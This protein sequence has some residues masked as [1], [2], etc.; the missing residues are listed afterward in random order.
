LQL[1]VTHGPVEGRT[2]VL[3][4]TRLRIGRDEGVDLALR[5]PRVSREHAELRPGADGVWILEDLGSTNHTFVNG[6]RVSRTRVGAGDEIQLG[7][8]RI[9]VLPGP[10]DEH[11]GEV[12]SLRLDPESL[13]RALGDGGEWSAG[14]KLLQ[15]ALF[16]VG[17]LA[18]PS[19]SAADLIH[20]TLPI[21]EEGVAFT[22]WAWLR[23]PDGIERPFEVVDGGAEEGLPPQPVATLVERAI[24]RGRGVVGVRSDAT[25]ASALA[26]PLRTRGM[27]DSLLYLERDPRFPTFGPGELAWVAAVVTQLAGHLEN[28]RLFANL[29]GAHERLR[30][31]EEQLAERERHATLGR[32]TASFA[33]DLQNP[34]ATVLGFLELAGRRARSGAADEKLLTHLDRAEQAADLCRALCRNLLTVSR[35]RPFPPEGAETC[36]VREVIE[37]TLPICAGAIE[38]AGAT[39]E[40]E[41]S[42]TLE[43]RGDRATLQ[44]VVMNLV[45]NAAEAVAQ[46]PA[47]APRRIRITADSRT[48]GQVQIEIA[49]NGPGI[50]SELRGR[51]FEPLVTGRGDGGGTGLGLYVV[52]RI[53][54]EAGGAIEVEEGEETIFRI[55]LTGALRPL[56]SEEVDPTRVPLSFP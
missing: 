12:L 20:R 14:G 36:R 53:V 56:S 3:G 2:I 13:R 52:S 45:V 41:A 38:R 11:T 4:P 17:L 31:A 54:A 9:D 24:R 34:L 43:I 28:A 26:L 18:D 15:E 1:T 48:D 19:R 27:D 42:P 8:T 35:H 47:E 44:Q 21:I 5:D 32:V 23:W 29:R 50:P 7:D 55:L 37:G 10:G 25:P 22:R 51:I 16:E 39:V 6:R 40:I 33:H 30:D 46:L 49:D